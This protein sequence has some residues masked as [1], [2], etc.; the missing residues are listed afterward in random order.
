MALITYKVEEDVELVNTIPQH[1]E[2]VMNELRALGFRPLCV[3]SETMFP[4][5]LLL[6]VPL[7]WIMRASGEIVRSNDA[8][9]I[10]NYYPLMLHFEQGIIAEINKMGVKYY[11]AFSDGSALVTHNDDTPRESYPDLKLW[12]YKAIGTPQ[13]AWDAHL[14]QVE[15]RRTSGPEVLSLHCFEQ[16]AEISQRAEPRESGA[17]WGIA[18]VWLGTCS[19]V[20]LCG[21]GA[22]IYTLLPGGE[23]PFT[24]FRSPGWIELLL[25][26]FAPFIFLFV[27]W[28]ARAIFSRK[29]TR[30]FTQEENTRRRIVMIVYGILQI[31][32]LLAMLLVAFLV[33][34]M[35]WLQF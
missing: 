26:I 30:N 21:L 25:I 5:S 7:Y 6:F 9:Q 22:L 1:Y 35:K 8:L 15:Q 28:I 3:V 29:A 2:P 12:R 32:C 34:Y 31:I 33:I 14:Q 11:S 18:A 19:F 17:L 4:F 13:A 24:N 10:V 20:L 23:N 27:V 16:F